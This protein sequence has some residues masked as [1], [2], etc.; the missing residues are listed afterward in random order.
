MSEAARLASRYR[1]FAAE[2]ARGRS[3]LYEALAEGVAGDEAVLALLLTLPEAKRQP[4]LLLAALQHR[5][6]VPRDWADAR[7]RLLADFPAIRAVMLARATQ[8]NEAGRCATLLP[9]LARLPQ[10]LALIEVGASA[11]LCLLPDAYGYDYGRLH[12][13]P[14]APDAPVFP[15][16]ADACTP[17]PAA[18]PRIVWRAG[19]DLSP[20]DAA[21]PEAAAWLRCLVW[22]EQAGRAARL[23]QAL[24]VAGQM[25]P[26]VVAGDL[27][28][29]LP[30]LAA[31]AP[32]DATLVVFHTAVLAYLPEQADREAFVT[33]AQRL[34]PAWI[35]NEAPSVLPS[36]AAAAEP[37]PEAGRFLLSLNGKPVAW[38]DPHG[39]AIDWIEQT[40]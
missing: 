4:N 5:Q 27:R 32:G 11:G 29:D 36:I 33:E 21:D 16:A 6:G 31:E 13:P 30:R 7:A 8:T 3:P 12:I 9:L 37:P 26:R 19:L 38:T 39:G 1:R 10:P 28:R 20:V 18:P 23:D 35:A 40:Y 22:P 14:P 15:C 34:A 17:L 25:R 2:E 24:R